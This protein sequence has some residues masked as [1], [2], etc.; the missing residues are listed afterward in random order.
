MDNF[1]AKQGVANGYGLIQGEA[2]SIAPGK[3]PLSSMTPTIVLEKDEVRLVVG[4][5]GGPTIIN[6]VFQIIMNVLDYGLDAQ[7]AV[8]LPRFH[9]Q[10]LPDAIQY[11]RR[12]LVDDVTRALEARGHKLL[13]RT[14]IG[15]A[16]VI[17]VDPQHGTRLGGADPRRGGLALGQ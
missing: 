3:R 1:S 5:P 2:N 14:S 10:W 4:T 15:D 7:Q 17:Y 8:D 9:H 11:E 6:T 13:E 12:G 16:Q